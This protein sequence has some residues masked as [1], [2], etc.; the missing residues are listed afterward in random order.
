M[1]K[2]GDGIGDAMT[3]NSTHTR[4]T[5]V[6]LCVTCFYN[7]H[8][9]PSKQYQDKRQKQSIARA[10]TCIHTHALICA[11]TF[12]LRVCVYRRHCSQ[13]SALFLAPK[14]PGACGANAAATAPSSDRTSS[15]SS[16][17]DSSLFDC[18]FDLARGTLAATAP[19]ATPAAAA[20]TAASRECQK[21]GCS[22]NGSSASSSSSSSSS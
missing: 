19:A 4:N 21:Q 13:A 8:N 16:S 14:H 22:Q 11:H 17:S 10:F 3:V 6:T 20:A 1:L 2:Q 18:L 7:K 9:N 12:T 15:D 5:F